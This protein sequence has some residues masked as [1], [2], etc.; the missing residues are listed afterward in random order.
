MKYNEI[1]TGLEGFKGWRARNFEDRIRFIKF[2]VMQMKKM[3]VR[4][5][6]RQQAEFINAVF[7]KANAF[8]K[9]LEQTEKGRE[10]LERLKED[11][12][13]SFRK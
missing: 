10:I 3:P 2:W 9:R 8:Y 7:E 5:W 12:A 1:K 11:R 13:R 4:E 6:S